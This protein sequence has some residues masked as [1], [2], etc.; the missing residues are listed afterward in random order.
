MRNKMS[1]TIEKKIE[2]KMKMEKMG[3]LKEERCAL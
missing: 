2:V 1:K 3:G